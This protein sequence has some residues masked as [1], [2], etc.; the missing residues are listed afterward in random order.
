MTPEAIRDAL[1][2]I[3]GTLE[4]QRRAMAAQIQATTELLAA[5]DQ[6]GQIIAQLLVPD[7]PW[8]DITDSQGGAS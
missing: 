4:T 8:S 3:H 1:L 2:L 6:Q 7:P 5:L